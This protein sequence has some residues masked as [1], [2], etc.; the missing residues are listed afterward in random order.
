MLKSFAKVQFK[1]HDNLMNACNNVKNCI[2]ND[3][4]LPVNVEACIALQE[5]L[6]E[7]EMEVNPM[8]IVLYNLTEF[9]IIH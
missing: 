2:L 5:L 7:D 6:N 8:G 3:T 9:T 4:C 1:S